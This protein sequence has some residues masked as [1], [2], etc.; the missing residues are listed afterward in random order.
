MELVKYLQSK[1]MVSPLVLVGL[2]YCK[3]SAKMTGNCEHINSR[4][5]QL[6]W[7]VRSRARERASGSVA[8]V[9]VAR[10]G[11]SAELAEQ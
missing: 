8:A 9:R 4:D 11:H 3:S 5:P 7:S 2:F 1:H 10:G 6:C